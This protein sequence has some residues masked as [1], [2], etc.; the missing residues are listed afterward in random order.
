VTANWDD[1]AVE[2]LQSLLLAW[3]DTGH[4]DL[5]WRRTSDPFAVLVSEVMLQQTQVTRVTPKFDAFLRRF[6]TLEALAAVPVADVIRAWSGLGYNRRAV[7][8]H[9][10]ARELVETG[11]SGLPESAVELQRLPGVGSYTAR[12]VASIAFGEAVA[13]VDTNV[14]RVLT[15]VVDGP[16]RS[17]TGT[18]VQALADRLLA[19]ERPGAWNE[20]LMELGATICLPVPDCP[21]CPLRSICATAPYAGTIRERRAGYRAS[22]G[23]ATPRYEVSTRFYRGRI[24]E[25]LRVVP[26]SAVLPVEDIGRRLR[27]DYDEAARPWLDGLLAGLARDGLITL[28]ADGASLPGAE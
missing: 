12:A 25:I 19:R 10:L 9:R 24:V 3:W 22:G 11:R 21:R 6:P 17:R 28:H 8:L 13:A 23:G 5:P 1:A 15:R 16:E 20:A 27:L 18:Q 4:R 7:N 26:D 2:R 14:Q